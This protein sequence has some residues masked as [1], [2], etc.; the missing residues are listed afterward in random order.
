MKKI[1]TGIFA[2]SLI[3]VSCGGDDGGVGS[4]DRDTLIKMFIS[5]G[6]MSQ[7]VAE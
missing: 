2:V 1:L 6:D 4:N 5:E 3:A 7:E